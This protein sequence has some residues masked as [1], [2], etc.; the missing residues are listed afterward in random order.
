MK[1]RA[2]SRKLLNAIYKT[3]NHYIW[4]LGSIEKVMS[5]FLEFENFKKM[6]NEDKIDISLFIY[7]KNRN[8]KNEI[9]FCAINDGIKLGYTFEQMS[10]LAN[11]YS[12][13]KFDR[14]LEYSQRPLGETRD[15]KKTHNFRGSNSSKYSKNA[16]K[17]RYPSK[18]RSRRTWKNFYALFPHLAKRDNWNGITS[19]RM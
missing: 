19:D 10:K 9:V 12:L 4:S 5:Y 11:D 18:N 1:N 17:H 16:C 13:L 8:Y 2:K 15:N 6:L 14:K 3:S 7:H